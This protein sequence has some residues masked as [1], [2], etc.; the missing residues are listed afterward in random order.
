M[1][2]DE[3]EK[4]QIT[5]RVAFY[6]RVSSE[7]QIEKY[8]IP[9]Q[10][11]SL[12]NL[13]SYKGKFPNGQPRLKLAGKRYIYQD[14][15]IS[16]TR[17]LFDR[18]GFLQLMDDVQSADPKHLPFDILAVY[19]VDR[20]ARKL[21]ILLKAIK[22]LEKKEIK[23]I[24]TQENIDTTTPFGKAILGIMGVIAELEIETTKERMVGGKRQAIKTRGVVMGSH[25][26]FGYKKDINK[27]RAI[28]EE[29]AQVV[30][31]IYREFAIDGYT[32]LEIASRLK[33]DEVLSPAASA[34]VYEK[35]TGDINKKN[36]IYHWR[37]GTI[38]KILSDETYLGIYY[39]NKTTTDPKTKKTIHIP[40]NKWKVSPIRHDFLVSKSLFDKAQKRLKE[41][42]SRRVIRKRKEDDYTYLLS[43]ILK[44]D[45]CGQPGEDMFS[46]GGNRDEYPK[47]SKQYSYTYICGRKNS[48][49]NSITCGVIPIPAD[50]LEAYVVEF[51]KA[52]LKDP[53]MAYKQQLNKKSTKVHLEH[54]QNRIDLKLAQLNNFPNRL[55][56]L[57]E[58]HERGYIEI[59]EYDQR[60]EDIE[61]E[62]IS[63]EK[64]MEELLNER[65]QKEVP[66]R[67][68]EVLEKYQKKYGPSLEVMFADREK[69]KLLLQNLISKIIVYSREKKPSEKVAGRP[70]KG[71][72]QYIPH[73]IKIVLRLPNEMLSFISKGSEIDKQFGVTDA[74][75]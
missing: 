4:K 29:E 39:Y 54:I 74:N 14:P 6:I 1:F 64:A 53:K 11:E 28:L 63:V 41:I 66:L 72:K 10:A 49:K 51:V 44:C 32:I 36:D 25:A 52:L 46:F 8:G 22:F 70:K 42:S 59:E 33:S 47:N 60:V 17:E 24:S 68:I 35:K 31:R 38:R 37:E 27:K 56:R 2:D 69:T 48:S 30:R 43:S 55:E 9:L 15:G 19:K 67:Y 61:K 23:L 7:D 13:L 62:K 3:I 45:H 65:S 20:L 73:N 50:Q 57:S 34:V 58:Q 71:T 26:E 75:L 18:P 21:E 40:K 12:N 5:Q 16:G